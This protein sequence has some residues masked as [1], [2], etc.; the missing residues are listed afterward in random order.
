MDFLLEWYSSYIL[1]WKFLGDSPILC[2]LST[3]FVCKRGGRVP[4]S[5]IIKITKPKVQQEK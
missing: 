1:N 4:S 5:F 3:I 2:F